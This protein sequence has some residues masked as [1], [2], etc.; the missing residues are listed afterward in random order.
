MTERCVCGH[1]YETHRHLHDSDYCGTCGPDTCGSYRP[2]SAAPII[3][4]ILAAVG[5]RKGRHRRA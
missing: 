4:G 3:A 2:E 5:L 1:L